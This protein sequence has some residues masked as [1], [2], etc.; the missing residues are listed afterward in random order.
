MRYPFALSLPTLTSVS[1]GDTFLS[2]F[3]IVYV[4][5][6]YDIE[7]NTLSTPFASLYD[8]DLWTLVV[9]PQTRAVKF[10]YHMP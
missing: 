3:T 4:S 7:Y 10:E 6:L 5:A 8:H 9:R 2:I 1:M